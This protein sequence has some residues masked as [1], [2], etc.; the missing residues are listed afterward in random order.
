MRWG[1][2]LNGMKKRYG[3]GCV[4]RCQKTGKDVDSREVTR[5]LW[6]PCSCESP[7]KALHTSNAQSQLCAMHGGWM[8]LKWLK[9][10]ELQ[11][12]NWSCSLFFGRASWGWGEEGAKGGGSKMQFVPAIMQR[13][14]YS[15]LIKLYFPICQIWFVGLHTTF[16]LS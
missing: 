13:G 9:V 1:K 16:Y 11:R 12:P 15:I 3:S 7:P 14:W 6:Q 10:V 8:L 5:Y 2:I 4:L